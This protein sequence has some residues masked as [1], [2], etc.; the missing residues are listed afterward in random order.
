MRPAWGS[1][2]ASPDHGLTLAAV[3]SI[4][5]MATE[6]VEEDEIKRYRE[7]YG[8]ELNHGPF[9]SISRTVPVH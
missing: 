1:R 3:L 6:L 8:R 9:D 2:P 7:Y 5:E 4:E